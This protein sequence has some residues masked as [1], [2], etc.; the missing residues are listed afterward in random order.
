MLRDHSREFASLAKAID[1]L[2]ATAIFWTLATLPQMTPDAP[3]REVLGFP[4]IALGFLS[5]LAWPVVLGRARLYDSQRRMDLAGILADLATAG[6][7]ATIIQAA[8][9]FTLAAPVSARFP[10]ACGLAQL[11]ALG[12]LRLGVF[13]SLRWLRRAGRNTRNVLIVGSGPRAAYVRQIIERSPSWGL[14]IEG[15]IDEG[16]PPGGPCV[17]ADRIFKLKDMPEI[18]KHRVIDEVVV[19]CPRSMLGSIVGVVDACAAAGV[20]I[21]LLSDVFGDYLPAPKVLRFG[22]LPALNFAPVHHNKGMLGVKRAIDFVGASL[23]L[24]LSL[25]VLAVAA[26]AIRLTSAGP[27]VFRQERCGLNGRRF[28]MLKL[29]TMYQDAEA[30]KHALSELNEMSGPVFKIRNDPRITPVG[31]WL[32]RLSI[33]EIP[34]LWNVVRGDMSLVGPRP[35]VP[36]EVADYRTFERRRLSMRPG[37]TCLWQI[38]GRNQIGF[39]DWV[40]LDCQYIDTWSV[41][42]DLRILARTI[43]AVLSGHGAS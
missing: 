27:V 28:T 38:N 14:E 1:V 8:A 34:Q 37:I 29:R 21:T 42:N 35:P 15:F 30:R 10:L 7:V 36:R 31:R 40:R 39:E 25:P 20:P 17:P 12:L 41:A 22:S 32:R 24:S 2:L 18:L 11:V 13:T 26:L 33:D 5:A 23:A 19:A 16:R 43:P 9:A 3:V 4:L 6:F